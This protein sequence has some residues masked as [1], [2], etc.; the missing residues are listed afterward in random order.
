MMQFISGGASVGVAKPWGG[1]STSLSR[2]PSIAWSAGDLPGASST[3]GLEVGAQLQLPSHLEVSMQ[4]QLQ[5][6][7]SQQQQQQQQQERQPQLPARS[8]S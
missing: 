5:L 6:Q 4:P 8:Q 2:L 1:R 7:M 3:D